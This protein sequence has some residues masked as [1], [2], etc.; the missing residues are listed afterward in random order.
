M[1]GDRTGPNPACESERLFAA[2]KARLVGPAEL[3]AGG[4][5]DGWRDRALGHLRDALDAAELAGAYRDCL[6][7]LVAA[8]DGEDDVFDVAAEARRLVGGRGE[9]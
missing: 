7:R 8:H 6:R 9:P 3:P 2:L 5:A 1:S 4:D